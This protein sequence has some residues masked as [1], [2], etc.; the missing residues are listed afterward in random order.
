MRDVFL[1][2][3]LPFLLYAMAKRPF[4][5][6]GLWI[7]TAL[8][9]P[10]AWVYGPAGAI[11]YNLLI[12]GFTIGGW[13]LAK[14]KARL[15][16]TNT[17]WLVLAFFAWTTIS[18]FLQIGDP[19]ATWDYWNRFW[20][21][22]VLFVF[23]LLILERKLH[24]DFFL[25]CVVLSIGFYGN[26]EA[27]KF[28]SSGGGHMIEGLPGHVLG[29]RNE[30]AVAFV[31]T[32]PICYYLMSEYGGK[33]RIIWFGLVCTMGLLVMGVI[34]T[35]SRGGFISLLVLGIYFF[36]KSDRKIVLSLAIGVLVFAVAQL[37]S[38]EWISRIDSIDSA[39][40][41][42][43]FMGRVVAWKLSF[44]LASDHP[45]FGGGFRAL[46]SYRVWMDLSQQFD[47]F[48]W[49][50]TGD[51][52]P[53][54]RRSHAAHSAYFQVMGDHGF[55]GLILYLSILLTSFTRSRRI[56]KLALR[57]G[58]PP[59]IKNLNT[60]VQL[61]LFSFCVGSA[62]LSFA[63]FDLSFALIGLLIVIEKRILPGVLAE[64]KE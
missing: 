24:I 53:D 44:I 11:R 5:A 42:A 25:W 29:D 39:N 20:K 1:L 59:W 41:D 60:M 32:L 38:S 48:P 33:S 40:Q 7:W 56:Q 35:Q 14:H 61:S 9:F 47:S 30:L 12:A 4:I 51:A 22:I 15:Q 57:P 27:L 37:A 50:Y 46:E 34:G 54:V 16:L 63:Y 21:I 17:G 3:I 6:L 8:F 13:L 2:A 26:L 43:S 49:F 23:V 58:V 64:R 19:I 31:M 10:N 36:I 18:S 28:V 62:A 45:L 52:V 55:A